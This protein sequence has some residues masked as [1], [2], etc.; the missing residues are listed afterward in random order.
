LRRESSIVKAQIRSTGTITLKLSPAERQAIL[1]FLIMDQHLEDRLRQLPAGQDEV[2]F[3]VLE[4][5][6]LFGWLN[7]PGNQSK[8]ED[9]QDKLDRVCE[10]IRRLL[11]EDAFC[12]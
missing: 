3:T 4:G 2:Q 1:G 7:A 9:V 8:N 5:T 11:P 10:R 12:D 6:A